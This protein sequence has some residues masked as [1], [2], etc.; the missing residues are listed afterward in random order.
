M[1]LYEIEDK[2]KRK[3]R[4]AQE[5]DYLDLFLLYVFKKKDFK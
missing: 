5:K 1:L 4:R 3:E 2:K